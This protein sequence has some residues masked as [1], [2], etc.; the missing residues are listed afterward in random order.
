MEKFKRWVAK[1]FYVLLIVLPVTLTIAMEC[2]PDEW[3]WGSLVGLLLWTV[4]LCVLLRCVTLRD[5]YL[6]KALDAMKNGCDPYPLLQETQE[7]MAYPGP[8]SGKQ[9]M[10]IN[11]ALALREIGEYEKA[12][13][14][15]ESI[16]I[17]KHATIPAVKLVYYNNRMD[18]CAL[19]GRYA[20][21]V[22]WYE[23]TAQIFGDMRQGKQKEQLRHAVEQ[24]LALFHYCK[25]E[26]DLALQVLGQ[27]KPQN[28][29]E[30]IEN[31]M[32]FA[33]TYLAMGEPE[34][35]KKP[36]RFVAENGNKLYFA[37]E[38]KELLEKIN[39]EETKL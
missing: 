18:I 25:G 29:N 19:T 9:I 5:R 38:A 6:R 37:T 7:Q 3:I 39:T 22:I 16:N 13:V 31:A 14:L 20:E 34:K 35:A 11:H 23:K 30:R 33:R 21:A 12:Q 4:M 27:A 1:H 24:N 28:M 2:I 8:K 15:M 32:M 10:A 17:D 36:L 26:F